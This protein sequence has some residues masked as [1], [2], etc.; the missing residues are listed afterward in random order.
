MKKGL[1]LLDQ[2]A[3]DKLYGEEQRRQIRELVTIADPLQTQHS[4]QANPDLL[5]EI[6]LVFSGWGCPHFSAELLA[7][8]PRLEAVFYGAGSIRHVVSEAFWERGIQI[9]TAYQAN[10]IPVSEFALAQILLSLKGYWHYVHSFRQTRQWYEHLSAAGGYGSTVGLISL[11]MVGR[12]LANKLKDYNLRVIAY[13]P[14]V[15]AET[16]AGLGVSLVS[17]EE[18][19]QHADVVSLHTPWLPETEGMIRGAHFAA[20]KPGATFINTARGAI[21]REDEMAA[22]LQTRPDVYA[23]LDVTYPEPPQPDSPLLKLP[24]VIITPHIAGPNSNECKRNGRYVVDELQRYLRG[25][26]L[27]FGVTRQQIKIMA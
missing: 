5:Q 19:F 11:G 17:L 22:V 1:F 9:S 3:Y 13:D 4:I 12:L 23:L 21:V 6:E 16:A 26:P 7:H 10:D 8:A 15:S 18:V 20:L 24:N 14:Y 2:A 27:H 25:E